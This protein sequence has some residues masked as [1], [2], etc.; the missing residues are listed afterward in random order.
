MI[1]MQHSDECRGA[2]V[3]GKL[4]GEC[5]CSTFQLTEV[6]RERVA[7]LI[8]SLEGD[9]TMASEHPLYFAV[10]LELLAEAFEKRAHSIRMQSK[11][12]ARKAKR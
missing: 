4:T 11:R 1:I 6:A 3:A 7:G 12:P 2:P 5:D 9:S 8:A 10:R